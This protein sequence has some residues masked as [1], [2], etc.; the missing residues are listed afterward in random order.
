MNQIVSTLSE[1]FNQFWE[2]RIERE[3]QFLVA[4]AVFF[5]L[6]LIYLVGIDP[7]LTGREEIRKSLPLLHQQAAQMQQMAQ[8]LVALPSPENRHEVSRETVEAGLAA[9]GLKAQSLSVSDG[10]V[11]AQFNSTTMSALQ[12]WLLEVQRSSGLFADEVK[13]TGLEG[14]T[15]SASLT[16]RQPVPNGAN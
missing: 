1:T 5:V 2:A 8:E 12:T 3:R 14:G 10:V 13:I 6:A 4:A 15:I 16:L 9:N 7:A 11:R